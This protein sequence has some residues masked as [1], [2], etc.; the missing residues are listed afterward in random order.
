M[1]CREITEEICAVLKTILVESARFEQIFYIWNIAVTYELSDVLEAVMTE[2]ESRLETFINNTE[3]I[4]WLNMLGWEEIQE[5]ITRNGICLES[6]SL[7]L[8]FVL[9]WAKDKVSNVEDYQTLLEL[10]LNLRHVF[11]KEILSDYPF[12]EKKPINFHLEYFS[13]TDPSDFPY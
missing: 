8:E 5:I 10:L 6:E 7:L 13:E 11:E 9:N 1:E 12:L 4:S 2:V 3:D